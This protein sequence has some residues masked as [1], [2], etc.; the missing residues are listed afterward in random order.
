MAFLP[1]LMKQFGPRFFIS[2][3]TLASF[4]FSDWTPVWSGSTEQNGS[5]VES[6][7]ANVYGSTK[8]FRPLCSFPCAVFSP[9]TGYARSFLSAVRTALSAF[10]LSAS[11]RRSHGDKSSGAQQRRGARFCKP[12]MGSLRSF[13]TSQKQFALLF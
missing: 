8:T 9:Q 6:Y 2:E 7:A 5:P 4:L 12:L 13:A 1:T 3:R 11:R 10:L